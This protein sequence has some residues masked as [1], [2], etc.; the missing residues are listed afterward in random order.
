MQTKEIQQT[1]WPAFFDNFSRQHDGTLVNLEIFG[2][3]MGDQFEGRALALEGMTAEWDEGSGYRLAIMM[4]AKPDDHIT[5]NI[6]KPV[7]V[8]LEQTD[9]GIDTALAIKAADGT[10]TLL[11]FHAAVVGERADA[12]GA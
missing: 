12:V 9:E 3:E 7:Q 2:S 4:G 6:S 5:H 1:E 8:N 11:R 10:T